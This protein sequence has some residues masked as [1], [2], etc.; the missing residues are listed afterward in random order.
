MRTFLKV[1]VLVMAVAG[2]AAAHEFHTTFMTIDHNPAEKNLEISLKVFRHDL[3]PV[4]EKRLGRQVDFG[5]KEE[6]DPAIFEY[7]EE[8][9]DLSL[10]EKELIPG[11]V[12][13]E[14]D[15][16]VILIYFEIPFD[17]DLKDLVVKNTLFFEKFKEQI[18]YVTLIDGENR[19]D[20]VFKVGDK[21]TKLIR[22]K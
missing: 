20:L 14:V 10:G 17:Q 19:S 13:K 16:Q 11:W 15:A 1:L 4:L 18:N 21:A 22:Q 12:G 7:V 9:F 5:V 8:N 6:I 3:E 2:S